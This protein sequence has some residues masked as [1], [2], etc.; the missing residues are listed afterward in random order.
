MLARELHAHVCACVW[1][2][3]SVL[4]TTRKI[5]CEKMVPPEFVRHG[6]FYLPIVFL[7]ELVLTPPVCSTVE[8]EMEAAGRFHRIGS[9]GRVVLYLN[10]SK[11]RRR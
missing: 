11:C 8:S 7:R 9:A 5:I 1:S 3:I 10:V 2:C 4:D 6:A